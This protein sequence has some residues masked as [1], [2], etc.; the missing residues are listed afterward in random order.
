MTAGLT[1]HSLAEQS[2]VVHR[3]I[4]D[5]ERGIGPA[6][7]VTLVL[8]P[9]STCFG[10]EADAR[11]RLEDATS[12]PRQR[13]PGRAG[14]RRDQ[15]EHSLPDRLHLTIGR[16]REVADRRQCSARVRLLTLTGPGGSG[17]T[18]LALEFVPLVKLDVPGTASSS[19]GR[20][21]SLIPGSWLQQSPRRS[22]S[23]SFLM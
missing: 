6:P 16:R 22:G 14:E 21:P 19:S 23:G 18:R 7:A 12:G 20:H 15:I 2:G 9:Q 1:Q 13:A 3:M 8:R 11:A 4:P 5:L 17:K 10:R